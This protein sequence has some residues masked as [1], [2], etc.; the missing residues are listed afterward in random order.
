MD[1][2]WN[3][4]MN[5]ILLGIGLAADAFSVSVVNGI[6][7]PKLK[8]SKACEMAGLFAFFQA[9]MPMTGWFL[10]HALMKYFQ[11]FQEILPK[12]SQGFLIYLGL[13]I[14]LESNKS[15]DPEDAPVE[16]TA[17]EL[18]VQAV[19]TSID[20]LLVGFTIAEYSFTGALVC[21]MIIALVTFILCFI[22]VHF[23]RKLGIRFAGR[24]CIYSGLLLIIMA[25]RKLL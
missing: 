16:L 17:K 18:L 21:S 9:L 23:G 1:L 14:I 22:G 15:G 4:V 5:S 25:L 3:F 2:L 6:S 7:H 19:A 10:V 11:I 20:A 24:A 8:T 13:R 12:I